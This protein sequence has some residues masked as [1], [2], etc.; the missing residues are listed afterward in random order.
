MTDIQKT[1]ETAKLADPE[2]PSDIKAARKRIPMDIP[3]RKLEVPELPGKYLYW[4]LESQVPAFI[5]A[6]YD[7]VHQS[8]LDVSNLDLATDRSTLGNADMGDRIRVF[9]GTTTN[10]NAEFHV[11]MW[12]PQELRDEDCK[13]IEERNS[14]ILESIFLDEKIMDGDREVS[15]SDAANRYVKTADA[16]SA[17]PLFKRPVKKARD[18]S[19]R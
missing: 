7:F 4:P 17:T 14:R 15:G 18:Q 10:G 11:L 13:A 2:K 1:I 5:Q 3:R 19:Q 12:L 6:G 8:E 9:A 16:K